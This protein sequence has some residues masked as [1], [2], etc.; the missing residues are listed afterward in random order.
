MEHIFMKVLNKHKKHGFTLIE[1]LVVISVIALLLSIL[2][3]SLQ[4]VKESASATVCASNV[5]QLGLGWVLYAG[6]NDDWFPIGISWQ[7]WHDWWQEG[8]WGIAEYL[9]TAGKWSDGT[10]VGVTATGVYK[11]W[12]CP[13]HTKEAINWGIPTGYH[14]NYHI[15]FQRYTRQ[16]KIPSISSTP[17]LYCF[18]DENPLE[19]VEP[20][21][22]LGNYFSCAANP[23]RDEDGGTAVAYRFMAG[24]SNVHGCGTNFMS[25]D[26]HTERVKPLEN[27]EAYADRFTW[28]IGSGAWR[29]EPPLF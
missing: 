2:M 17:L 19:E 25:A 12:Y 11:G 9:P 14:V 16:S 7:T 23:A 22:Y 24:I 29:K 26:L 4:K 21:L 5:K 8:G 3:P 20:P 27:Q 10:A 6:D 28:D 1:L 13:R 15:G 18:W